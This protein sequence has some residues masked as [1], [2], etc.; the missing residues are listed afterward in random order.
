MGGGG[1]KKK[2]NMKGVGGPPDSFLANPIQKEEKRFSGRVRGSMG[3]D[4]ADVQIEVPRQTRV[5]H[6]V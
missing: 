2:E 3:S 4:T 5:E 1:R 6:V